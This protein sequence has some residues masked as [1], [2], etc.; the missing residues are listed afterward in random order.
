M[1]SKYQAERR[2]FCRETTWQRN[3]LNRKEPNKRGAAQPSSP[4]FLLIALGVFIHWEVE[5]AATA[6]LGFFFNTGFNRLVAS[7]TVT[8]SALIEVNVSVGSVLQNVA[9][10]GTVNSRCAV[11]VIG[12]GSVRQCVTLA[13]TANAT[14]LG[15]SAGSICPL[16]TK[17]FAFGLTANIAGLGSGTGCIY[18]IV[19]CRSAFG[20]A[21]NVTG[22]GCGAACVIP[23]VAE[24]FALGL[25][26]NTAGLGSG[27]GRICPFVTKCF[28]FGLAASAAGLGSGAGCIC[29][30]VTECFAVGFAAGSAGCSLFASCLCPLVA[31][32][33]IPCFAAHL[34]GGGGVAGRICHIV[35]YRASFTT[36]VAGG[37]ASVV[38]RVN[39]LALTRT[40]KGAQSN[41]Q[42]G[43]CKY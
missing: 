17:R 22:L 1:S 25:T 20:L 27:A 34:A 11:A 43:K 38:I 35:R 30:F 6:G 31:E 39:T 10:G 3:I 37:V 21:A 12:I 42:Y 29:P 5:S 36:Q 23:L 16:V 9:A 26:T 24:C 13:L 28:A 15:S 32:R 7:L 33:R 19:P 4:S 18:P 41:D 2:C 8:Q 40:E 14:G